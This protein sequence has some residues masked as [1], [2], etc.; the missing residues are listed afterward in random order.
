[1]T[2]TQPGSY[3]VSLTASSGSLQN[4]TQQTDYIVVSGTPV[5]AFS[6]LNPLGSPSV[7]FNNTTTGANSYLWNFGDGSESD[8]PNPSH[9]Y[10]ADGTY[11]VTLIATNAC[12][13]DTATQI[14]TILLPPTASWEQSGDEG[15]EGLSVQFN[16]ATQG[17]GLTYAWTF[18]G[19]E[20]ATSD[21]P[22]PTV[23]YASAGSYPVQLIIANAAGA[24][25]AV[26]NSAIAVNPN[27]LA[28]FSANN[29]L[30]QA[31]VQFSNASSAASSYHWNFGDGSE[32]DAS[33]P[34]HSYE[35]DGVYTVTLIATNA[36]GNDTATQQVTI[37]LPPV[38]GWE[39]NGSEGCEG[40]S[41]QF[42]A[43]A[44]GPGLTYAWTFAGGE[45]A[46]SDLPNPTVRYASAGS[47]PVQLII[48]N[49]AGADTAVQ[50][51]AIAI[52]PNPLAAF[53][54]NNPLG[55]ATVQ[56]SNASTAASNYHWN[57]GDGS[58]SDAS[59]PSHGYQAD[60]TY[61]VTLIATNACGS[62]TATQQ[63]TIL[64]PPV[65]GW[66]QNGSEG[67]EGLSVQFNAAAQG[68]GLTYAWTF[69]GGEPATSD[70]PNP[71]VLYATAGNSAV[72]LIVANAAGSD[73]RRSK[74][75]HCH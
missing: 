5:T 36:C 46:T 4:S 66:E 55:Q 10:Q 33:N 21:L 48:A 8:V 73:T 49:A 17:S 41:V 70:L 53:A 31:A 7:E 30:G 59:N 9:S 26:Q 52:N 39:Q 74:Q 22:N 72:Q 45:P 54:A 38:A 34:S 71:T 37:L 13:N 12:G 14:V 6:A 60:G 23:R 56:F 11:T 18:A 27:P 68:P 75:R 15:C 29:P 3:N 2:Y 24:D 47:Y 43:A 65:A 32:S 35:A 50:N 20:P 40:L 51:S 16:A 44:Q 62:D 64:L 42:N 63:V 19:G 1:M 25:T 67:C 58:E 69:A 28:A 57:F 61:T